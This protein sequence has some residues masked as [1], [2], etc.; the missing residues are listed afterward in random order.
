M[1][2]IKTLL[3]TFTDVSF[4]LENENAK[5]VIRKV[6]EFYKNDNLTTKIFLIIQSP[7]IPV[8]D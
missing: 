5:K 3:D 8:G 6:A 1:R 4:D 2:E 7:S